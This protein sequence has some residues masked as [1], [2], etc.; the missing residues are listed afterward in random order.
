[1][2]QSARISIATLLAAIVVALFGNG[3]LVIHNANAMD[4]ETA[5]DSSSNAMC[6][7]SGCMQEHGTCET[8][9]VSAPTPDQTDATLIDQN[10]KTTTT[11]KVSF[12]VPI[13]GPPILQATSYKLQP[14]MLR[15][16]KSVIKR[17]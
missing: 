5:M 11:I 7:A 14:P 1:M 2:T 4:H 15:H 12:S 13:L 6:N 8:H 16:I 17:E 9:C 3:M 10:L